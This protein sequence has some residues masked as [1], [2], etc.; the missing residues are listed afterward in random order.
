MHY[1]DIFHNYFHGGEGSTHGANYHFEGNAFFSYATT[2]ALKATDDSGEEWLLV[3]GNSMSSY[4]GRHLNY[5]L[6]AC[7][8]DRRLRI[9]LERGDRVYDL[10]DVAVV[11][12]GYARSMAD[13]SFSR[14]EDRMK[15]EWLH[16]S[17][18]KFLDLFK[19]QLEGSRDYLDRA[20]ET[21]A[22]CRR[23]CDEKTARLKAAQEKAA[24]RTPEEV[25]AMREKRRL[26]EE[27]RQKRIEEKT[28]AV[29]AMPYLLRI[30]LLF[31]RR[32]VHE[33]PT[34]VP[35]ESWA[36]AAQEMMKSGEKRGYSFMW[37]VEGGVRTSQGVYVVREEVE[38]A[39]RLY[40]RTRKMLGTEIGGFKVVRIDDKAVQV[41]CHLIPMENVR[42]VAKAYGIEWK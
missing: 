27:R 35:K 4:T 3:S 25:E 8:H 24:S 16:D 20:T 41:G 6:R 19:G 31:D 5:L 9:P 37:P 29:M 17:F 32:A 10:R 38:K 34:D 22:E 1:H 42:A 26:A 11:W 21:L 40:L 36:L 2:I 18:L 7:P 30:Q 15:F 14:V 13:C 39:I 28:K 33:R 12:S 23:R